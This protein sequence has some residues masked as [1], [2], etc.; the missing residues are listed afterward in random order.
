VL[1]IWHGLRTPATVAFAAP[2]PA[3]ERELANA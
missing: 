1:G 3:R 2:E